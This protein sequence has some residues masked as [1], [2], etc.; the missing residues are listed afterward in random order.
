MRIWGLLLAIG[1]TLGGIAMT[2]NVTESATGK[3][4]RKVLRHVV[5]YKFKSDLAPD[6][7]QEVVDAFAR[8]PKQIETIV[9]FEHGA[10]VSQEGKSEGLTH[11]FVVSFR[12]ETGRATYLDHAAHQ[13]YVKL[14][15]GR[16]EKVIVFDYWADE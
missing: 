10:N 9:G 13:E 1:V 12:D 7:V 3:P 2:N 14:V 4:P 5:L 16:R 15:R 11:C 8:L 6:K